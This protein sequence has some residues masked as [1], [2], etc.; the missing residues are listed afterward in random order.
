[1]G[2]FAQFDY[3]AQN[4][5]MRTSLA[6]LT[7]F[8]FLLLAGCS[9]E[10]ENLEEDIIKIQGF[11]LTDAA[12]NQL[13][14]HGNAADDWKLQATLSPIEMTLLDF[15]TPL[16]L[17]HTVESAINA[18][19]SAYPN[20]FATTQR[21][22]TDA[23]D[24]VLFRMAVVDAKLNVLKTHAAKIKGPYTI[25]L[26]YSDRTLF[27][28]RGAYRVYYSYSAQGKPHFKVGYGDIKLCDQGA[29]TIED[30]FK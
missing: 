25:Q 12:G 3:F 6:L 20:P 26:D 15:T 30:C 11:L 5:F 22:A 19:V 17:D 14:E 1:M 9:C 24:S 29:A 8:T 23:A 28:A 16:T 13:G 2:R 27:S 10:K 18:S 4:I 7:C 21:Y